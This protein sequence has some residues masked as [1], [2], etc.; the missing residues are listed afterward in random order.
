MQIG[1]ELISLGGKQ[2]K[3]ELCLLLTTIPKVARSSPA[4]AATPLPALAGGALHS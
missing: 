1:R 4:P 2:K 3:P